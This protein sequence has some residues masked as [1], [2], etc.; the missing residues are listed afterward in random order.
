VAIALNLRE[1]EARQFYLEYWNLQHLY[2]L[3]RIY[4]EIKFNI[5]YFVNLYKSAVAAGF[6]IRQVIRLQNI[7]NND[8][9]AVENMCYQ[10]RGGEV[11]LKLGNENAARILQDLG[12]QISN[13]H[14]ELNRYLRQDILTKKWTREVCGV[15]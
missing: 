7:A 12:N 11:S 9:P 15:V 10:L 3:Y 13:E 14:W 4:Q 2:S 6:N 5:E 1:P 8:L